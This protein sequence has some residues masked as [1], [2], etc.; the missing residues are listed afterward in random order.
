LAEGR[1]GYDFGEIARRLYS[2]FWSEF[3]DWYI[4]FSKNQL[5]LGG[6]ERVAAQRNLVFVLDT[7][8][9][10]LHPIM[11]FLTERIWLSL[12]HGDTRPSLMVAAWPSA[13]DLADYVNEEAE[14]AIDALC[15]VVG[16]VRAAR[17]RYGISPKEPLDVVVRAT[18]ADNAA[19][20]SAAE[21]LIAQASQVQAMART[22]RF[23]VSVDAAKPAQSV[24]TIAPPLEI[25]VVLEGLVDFDA[26]RAR[27]AKERGKK[28]T[29]LEKLE[30]K[31]ANEGFLAKADVTVVEKARA[32]AADLTAA[33]TQIDQQL[34][35]LD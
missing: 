12:P 3:C 14:R 18:G 20:A 9:R 27:L 2:F 6:V 17:A 21:T 13:A 23:D 4:E 31:L 24:V 29:D 5:A 33:I 11:P 8:L 16:A 34:A 25:Y 10:L 35:D 7:A 28:A 32:D 30:K 22:A 1:E 26:E 19:A 15:A